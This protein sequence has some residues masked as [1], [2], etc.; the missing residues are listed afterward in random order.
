MNAKK[1]IEAEDPKEMMQLMHPIRIY[2]A[3]QGDYYAGSHGYP[4]LPVFSSDPETLRKVYPGAT[5][6]EYH[7]QPKRVVL[8]PSQN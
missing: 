8:K 6:I 1:I 4:H 3:I 7:A 2:I 5:I